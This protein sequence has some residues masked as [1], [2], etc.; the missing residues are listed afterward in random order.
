MLDLTNPSPSIG[1][2]NQERK[3]ITKRSNTDTVMALALIH[4]LAISNNLPLENIA[5]YFA[6]L[7]KHLI[8]EFVPKSDS[9]VK[10]LLASRPDIFP[11]YTEKGFKTAFEKFFTI[12]YTKKVKDSERT[13]YLMKKN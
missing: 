6:K 1:W 11:N 4:H 8:I 5:E 9:K 10:T 13:I 2:A 7:A 12:T 3:S